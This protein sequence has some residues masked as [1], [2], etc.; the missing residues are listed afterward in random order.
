M[1]RRY[2]ARTLLH[3]DVVTPLHGITLLHCYAL[4]LLRSYSVTLLHYYALTLLDYCTATLLHCYALTLLYYYTL[5][6]LRDQALIPNC[7]IILSYAICSHI[8]SF[9]F[10]Y[11]AFS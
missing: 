2:Y 4:K 11:Y 6:L 5:S 8:H 9:K 10:T 1:L 7:T 3:F